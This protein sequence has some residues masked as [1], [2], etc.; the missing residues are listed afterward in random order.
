MKRSTTLIEV[1]VASFILAAIFAGILASFVSVRK[2]VNRANSRLDSAN[3][4]RGSLSGL[5]TQV[6][7]DTW[8]TTVGNLSDGFSNSTPASIDGSSYFV[9]YTVSNVTGHDFRQ[10][11]MNV[12]YY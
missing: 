7:A 6:S 8:N 1:M 11:V 9:N 4:A 5:S 12:S 10:V 2:Y 3:L